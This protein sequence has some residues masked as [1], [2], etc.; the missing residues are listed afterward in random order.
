MVSKQ[1]ILAINN[2][3]TRSNCFVSSKVLKKRKKTPITAL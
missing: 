2:K 3:E 1:N